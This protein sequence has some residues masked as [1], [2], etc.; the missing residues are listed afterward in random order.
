MS[1][2]IKF[3]A[4]SRATI[5][6]KKL[7]K[8]KKISEIENKHQNHYYLTRNTLRKK[9]LDTFIIKKKRIYRNQKK[10]L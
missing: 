8:L 3:L 2:K 1:V 4:S 7:K 9:F 10:K 5:S 6:T